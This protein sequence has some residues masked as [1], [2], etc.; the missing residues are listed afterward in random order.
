VKEM[1]KLEEAKR[2]LSSRISSFPKFLIVLGSGLAGLLEEIEIEAQVPYTDIPYF[3]L[4]TVEGHSGR[5]IIGSVKGTTGRTRIACMQGRLHYYE[6]LSMSDVVFPFRLFAHSG[7]EVALLTNASGGLSSKLR[8]LDLVLL[9]DHINLMGSNPLIGPN[10]SKLGERF[11]DLTHLYDP[12]LG[13]LF[14]ATA[15]K[16]KIPLK[17]GVYVGIHGP[18]YETPA[19]IRMYRKL[20]ADVVGMSTIPEAIALHHMKKRVVAISCVTNLAAGVSKTP[21]VHSEVLD[22]AKKV[23]AKFSRLVIEAFDKIR[24]EYEKV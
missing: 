22:N 10:E 16:L 15:K 1:V 7:V 20:G 11:P 24:L 3:K 12:K 13:K 21:L 9:N 4:P 6:G 19:E 17:N 8:P 18:S 2:Y 5:L 23:H 14:Q